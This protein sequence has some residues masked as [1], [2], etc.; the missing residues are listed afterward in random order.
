MG[1]DTAAMSAGQW[2]GDAP[3]NGTYI[4]GSIHPPQWFTNYHPLL[5]RKRG[6]VL[7]AGQIDQLIQC[8]AKSCVAVTVEASRPIPRVGGK[9][10]VVLFQLDGC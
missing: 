3:M 6:Y 5:E 8:V 1:D 9:K 2:S 7:T 10:W 4:I